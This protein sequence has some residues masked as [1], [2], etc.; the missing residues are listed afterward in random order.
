MRTSSAGGSG[1]SCSSAGG[2]GPAPFAASIAT[3]AIYEDEF[4][5]N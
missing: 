1:T 5:D 2:S 3:S 4:T